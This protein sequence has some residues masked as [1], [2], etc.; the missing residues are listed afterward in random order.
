MIEKKRKFNFR[1]FIATRRY[2]ALTIAFATAGVTILL[3]AAYPQVGTI[4]SSYKKLQSEQSRLDKLQKKAI[5]LEQIKLLPEFAQASYVDEVLPSHKPVLELLTSL[6]DAANN[7]QVIITDFVLSPG[8]IATDSTK[9]TSTRRS[10]TNYDVLELELT[11]A[12]QLEQVE[13]FMALI[14]RISPITTITD[15]A[16]SRTTSTNQDTGEETI[17]ARANLKLNTFF[18]T[19]SIKSSIEATLPQIGTKEQNIFETI[20][21][22]TPSNFEKQTEVQ[23]GGQTD[24][25][26]IDK[27]EKEQE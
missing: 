22:F 1:L 12:G 2:L 19:Q 7:S 10:N 5:E 6:N 3:F 21:E 20:R 15:I 9:V 27:L 18:F 11:A 4:T 14:E 16:L 26:G 23:G 24:F 25:F 8:E 13:K 17:A